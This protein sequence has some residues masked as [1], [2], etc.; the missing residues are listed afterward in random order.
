[1]E[2]DSRL[3]G[4]AKAL[5]GAAG[6]G[7]VV[8]ALILRNRTGLLITVIILVLFLLCF[9]GYYLWRRYR[10]KQQSRQFTAALEAQT[11]APPKSISDPNRR[12]A[13]DKLRQKFQTGMAQFKTRDKDLYK[14]PWYIII[15]EP[16]S[17]KTEAIRHS[18]IDFPP[19]MQDELQGSGGTVNMDWWFTNRGIILDTAGSMIF[20]EAGAGDSPEWKEFLRLLKKSRPQSPVNGLFLVLSVESLIK[21][22]ADRIAQKASRLA[23]QLDLIQRALDVRFPVY[24]LVTKS[25]LLIGFREFFDSNDP[26]FQYQ[27]F[28]WSN[29]DPLDSHFRPDLV[30]QHLTSVAARLRRRRLALLRDSSSA[31]RLGD[32][33]PFFSSTYQLGKGPAPTRRLDEMDSLFALPESVM[34]LAPRLRRYLETIFVAGEWSAKPV[35]LRGIYFTSSMR[36]GKALDEA[37]ALATGLPLD[38][39][40]EERSWEKNRAFF[41]RDLFMEKVFRES[42][43][44]TR[45]TNTLKMLRQRQLLI[46]GTAGAAL[47]LLLGFATYGYFGLKN[48]VGNESGYWQAGAANWKQGEWSPG[49]IRSGDDPSRF[50]YAETNVVEAANNPSVVEFHDLLK[51]KIAGGFSTPF[52]F[53]PAQ[54]LGMGK[55][56]HRA[57]AQRVL[58]ERGVLLPVISA[59]RRKMEAV[60]PR[61]DDPGALVR[62]REALLALVQ[63]EA[64]LSNRKPGEGLSGGTNGLA[65]AQKYLNSFVSYLTDSDRKVSTNLAGVFAWTYLTNENGRGK[66]SPEYFSGGDRLSNN[67]AIKAG[68]QAFR[69]ANRTNEIRVQQE[70]A[71]VNNLVRALQDYRAAEQ[72]W[73]QTPANSCA[74]LAAD[75][76]P[77]KSVV[78]G[79]WSALRAQTNF[80][81]GLITNLNA[82]Y[83]ALESAAQGASKSSMSE[84]TAGLGE[85]A[86]GS[87]II[88][89]VLAALTSFGR[90]SA[91]AVRTNRAAPSAVVAELDANFVGPFGNKAAFE[92]RWSLYHKACALRNAQLGVTRDVI[93][94]EWKQ[95]REL[96]S[97]AD[98]FSQGLTNYSGPLAPLVAN[99]CDAI[100]GTAVKEL[101]DGY[102]S[103][104][105]RVVASELA[106]MTGRTFREVT[107][108]RSL[109]VRVQRDLI[110]GKQ[111][112]DGEARLGAVRKLLEESRSAV[113]SATASY[114]KGIIGFPVKFDASAP[115]M[116]LDG[117]K[118]LSALLAGLS[119][120]LA[121]PI[122]QAD[123]S[124]ALKSLQSDSAR[125]ATIVASLV[126][127]DGSPVEWELFF[128]PPEENNDD[129][130]IIKVFPYAQVT[131]GTTKSV[132]KP[133]AND[134]NPISF[135]KTPINLPLEIAFRKFVDPS[136]KSEMTVLKSVPDWGLLRVVSAGNVE[137]RD[138]GRTWRFKVKL[139]DKSQ[140]LSGNAGFEARLAT[141]RGLPA[142]KDWP[143]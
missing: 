18:G 135:G 69:D 55:V 24:L 38:Q 119:E 100:A 76:A 98:Q 13:L 10:A 26:D 79:A 125:Y 85:T 97:S 117:L 68:L 66:W 9:G 36:E 140:S 126:N 1:M 106:S 116:N 54:W 107:N 63:L 47:L 57:E 62:H 12:A 104:Y 95:F 110:A 21:D 58:F 105:L 134:R 87:G 59:T 77:L 101:K 60:K 139:E 103:E 44:V 29:P 143:Q 113:L 128:V 16:A 46:F 15:G 92:A 51:K 7:A 2:D 45:A 31:G 17:G 50:A 11:A 27:M 20:N 70:L 39:L 108:S 34:R 72:V 93:G 120:E 5:L 82:R 121:H 65:V 132:W 22:S 124:P 43:L 141:P 90:E 115:A 52:I 136:D 37:I 131:L 86:K 33:Q 49:V 138:D 75:V 123:T 80:S 6:L 129:H 89:E 84:I 81:P 67:A 48:T 74:A 28:G 35:F 56:K 133:I 130:T 14:L 71:S 8:P 112:G 96:Q 127:A 19:G 94:D 3:S 83:V 102:V 53:K 41:L 23:Q 142:V 40:P 91:E 137:R 78:D 42:G 73:L 61:A 88:G 109:F 114:V 111:L 30:E 122:W 4:G 25:D 118:E 64:E 99:V 32:S